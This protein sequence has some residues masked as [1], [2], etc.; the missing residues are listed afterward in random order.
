LQ[1]HRLVQ[2]GSQPHATRRGPSRVAAISEPV[3]GRTIAAFHQAATPAEAVTVTAAPAPK[4]PAMKAADLQ[5][6][7]TASPPAPLFPRHPFIVKGPCIQINPSD[8]HCI[9]GQVTITP[10]AHGQRPQLS[11]E[12]FTPRPAIPKN[13]TPTSQ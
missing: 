9:A 11:G 3:T 13:T 4:I 5:A 6:L 12:I 8:E 2:L 7:I 1:D 10:G